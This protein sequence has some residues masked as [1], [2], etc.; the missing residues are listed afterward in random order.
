MFS[1]V[2]APIF[3][4]IETPET[5]PLEV[6]VESSEKKFTYFSE[7]EF[8]QESTQDIEELYEKW[9]ELKFYRLEWVSK[10]KR[11]A[12]QQEKRRKRRIEKLKNNQEPPSFAGKTS[13]L[14]AYDVAKSKH[15]WK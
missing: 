9:R 7:E 15:S 14:L 2:N 13:F 11:R 10:T 5:E 8:S 12:K 6:E 3:E 4:Q 1:V